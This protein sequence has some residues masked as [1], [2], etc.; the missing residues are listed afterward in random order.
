MNKLL[1]LG[2]VC[3][4]MGAVLWTQHR[5]LALVRSENRRLAADGE[6]LAGA[7]AQ[8]QKGGAQLEED[9]A[10][11]LARARGLRQSLTEWDARVEAGLELPASLGPGQCWPDH[12][13]YC[14]LPKATLTRLGFMTFTGDGRLTDAA[15][16]LF[17]MSPAE[18]AR[19]EDAYAAFSQELQ[20]AD[21]AHLRPVKTPAE[22]H[23]W[24]DCR[25]QSYALELPADQALALKEGFTTTVREVLAADQAELFLQVNQ[26]FFETW[27]QEL[28]SA[29]MRFTTFVPLKPPGRECDRMLAEYQV[30]N[31]DLDQPANGKCLYPEDETALAFHRFAAILQRYAEQPGRGR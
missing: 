13:P 1:T 2:L 12:A 28:D 16:L 11:E 21:L 17:G 24:P 30:S 14:Y 5:S 29:S 26:R 9:L 19:I 25:A 6:A 8:K 4:V 18:R 10:A 27:L 7:L 23:L 15:A 31:M 22:L 3:T 20:A